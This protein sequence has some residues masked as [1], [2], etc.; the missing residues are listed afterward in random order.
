MN[1]R[2]PR[3]PG[4]TVGLQHTP[5]SGCANTPTGTREAPLAADLEQLSSG[6]GSR[7]RLP[8]PTQP[9]G[10]GGSGVGPRNLHFCPLLVPGLHLEKHSTKLF[11]VISHK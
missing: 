9:F 11:C 2:H 10:L 5:T 1:Q 4:P 6:S 3:T 7:R 8:R